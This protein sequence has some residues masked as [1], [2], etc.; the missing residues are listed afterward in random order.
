[1]CPKFILYCRSYRCKMRATDE[2]WRKGA[3]GPNHLASNKVTR[4]TPSHDCLKGLEL[5]APA[6]CW[7]RSVHVALM[8]KELF[9]HLW[10]PPRTWRGQR[11]RK[12]RRSLFIFCH[13][14]IKYSL[15]VCLEQYSKNGLEA[16][17][18]P[19]SNMSGRHGGFGLHV[20]V[21]SAGIFSGM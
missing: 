20:N 14:H 21:H 5:Y 1:M 9:Y 17:N 16:G 15:K 8:S 3:L 18:K 4:E 2:K 12:H 13:V 6:L 11:T 7:L 10:W 19:P